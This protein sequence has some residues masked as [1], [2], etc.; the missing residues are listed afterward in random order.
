MALGAGNG[1]RGWGYERLD[2]AVGQ[3]AGA[4]IAR[5]VRTRVDPARRR[6]RLTVV[7][8]GQKLGAEISSVQVEAALLADAGEAVW[9][10]VGAAVPVPTGETVAVAHDGDVVGLQVRVKATVS[11]RTTAPVAVEIAQT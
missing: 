8:S 3:A 1:D 7:V 10:P 6:C 9:Y 5:P 2:L 11:T 4:R